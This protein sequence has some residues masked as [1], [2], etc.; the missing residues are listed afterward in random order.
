M[1]IFLKL[2]HWQLFIL[3]ILGAIQLVLFM[4]TEFWFV[5]LGIYFGL[6]FGWVY[7]IGNVLNKTNV[8]ITKKLNVWSILYLISIIPMGIHF[9]NMWSVA[10]QRI[11]PLLFIVSGI[12][13]FFSIVNIGIIGAK[14][15]QEKEKQN[16]LSFGNYAWEFFMILYMLIGVWF[17]QPRL[18]KLMS[19]K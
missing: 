10:Y 16:A 1:Y 8:E 18:N 19:D 6:F 14:S 9:H 11:H 5:G 4:N 13:G 12:I 3:W 7:S 17:L 15:I 2:K